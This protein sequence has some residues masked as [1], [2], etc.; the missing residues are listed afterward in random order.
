VPFVPFHDYFPALAEQETRSISILDEANPWNLPPDDYGFMELFCDEPGCDCRRVFLLVLSPHDPQ[1][2]AVIAYGWEKLRFYKRWL[3]GLGPE[4]ARDL[5]GPLLNSGSPQ[6]KIAPSLLRLADD[7]LLR[8]PAYMERTRRHYR[9]M[10]N[11]VD[12]GAG[13]G[14]FEGR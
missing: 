12:G 8:D 3:R 5:K 9:M 14:A 1:P 13:G 4:E 6:S 11:V 10:R 7:M 2:K